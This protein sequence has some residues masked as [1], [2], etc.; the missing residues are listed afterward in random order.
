LI[1][2]Q[3]GPL[4]QTR[5]PAVRD[6]AHVLG[7]WIEKT[8]TGVVMKPRPVVFGRAFPPHLRLLVMKRML[9][10]GGSRI[11]RQPASAMTV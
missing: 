10:L 2:L 4:H 7:S 9:M 5:V 6:R 1:G 3:P 8:L 11:W